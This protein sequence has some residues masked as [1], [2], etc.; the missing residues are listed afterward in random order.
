MFTSTVNF[1]TTSK[2]CCTGA[3]C[4]CLFLIYFIDYAIIVIPCFSPFYSPPSWTPFLPSFPHLSSCPW[5]M[6]ISSLASPFPILFLTCPYF[7]KFIYLFI[8]RQRGRERE[9][10]GEEHW[11][12]VAF[13]CLLLG[14][15]PT[16]QACALGSE[17]ATFWFAGRCS[18]QWATPARAP[19]LFFTY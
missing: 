13:M 11:C 7:L 9:R 19:C 5:V 14:I 3:F 8:F 1:Y 6:H 4:F 2:F 16:T 10:E 15:W 18:I 17:L 12:V